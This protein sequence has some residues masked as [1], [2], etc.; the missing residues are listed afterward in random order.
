M[1]LLV[2]ISMMIWV[3]IQDRHSYPINYKNIGST[4]CSNIEW[5]LTFTKIIGSQSSITSGTFLFLAPDDIR[6]LNL[7][8]N[9]LFSFTALTAKATIYDQ[10]FID[11][12]YVINFGSIIFVI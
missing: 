12:A 3:L 2:L 4:G 7:I 9:K 1:Q 6:T 8:A 10:I 5:E 11:D